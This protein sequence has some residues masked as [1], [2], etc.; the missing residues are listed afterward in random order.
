MPFFVFC[1]G[2]DFDM[3]QR[4]LFPV[5][6]HTKTLISAQHFID[7]TGIKNVH[8][9]LGK[10]RLREPDEEKLETKE[11]LIISTLQSPKADCSQYC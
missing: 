9:G 11:G 5:E 8:L 3:P 7:A 10:N 6:S 4:S 2:T 1:N